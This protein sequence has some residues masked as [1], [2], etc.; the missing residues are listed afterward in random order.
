MLDGHVHYCCDMGAERLRQAAAASG[1]DAMALQCIP[2]AG[3]PTEQDALAFA[4]ESTIP[5]YVFGGIDPAVY[6]KTGEELTSALLCALDRLDELGCTGLKMLEGKP[7][8]RYR[9][10]MPDFDNRVW[11]PFWA[12]LEHEQRPVVMHLCDPA[13]FWDESRITPYAR[14][15]GWFYDKR[16]PTREG[17]YAQMLRVLS[18]HG[19]LRILFPHM[20]F[21]GGEL[22][23]L[24]GILS[25]YPHVYT[26]T[27]PALEQLIAL[28]RQPGAARMFFLKWRCRI[29]YGTDIGSRQIVPEEALP[30]NLTESST[31]V[32]CVRRLLEE[33]GEFD[34]LPGGD[35]VREKTPVHVHG[36]GLEDDVLRLI[37]EDNFRTFAKIG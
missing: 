15:A 4:R 5:V 19:R 11:E 28:G 20:M 32:S 12:R 35:F 33:K 26:D 23:R 24:D 6:A 16:Y 31:R 18:R 21:F 10:P 2:K 30:L 3:R 37:Y 27:T 36:L 8:V 17:L 1:L 25:L 34:I 22:G 13:E 9:H 7:D 29:C 14:E